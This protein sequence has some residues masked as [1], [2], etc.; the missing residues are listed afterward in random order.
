LSHGIHHRTKQLDLGPG[1]TMVLYTDGL[2]DARAPRRIL[3]EEDLEELLQRGRGL[4]AQA[5]A[6]FIEPGAT[7]GQDPVTTSPCL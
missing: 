1:D 4:D 7:G 2:T 3:S 5:L 6:E